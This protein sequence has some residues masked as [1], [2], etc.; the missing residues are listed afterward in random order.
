MLATRIILLLLSF[1]LPSFAG[2]SVLRFHTA[3]ESN[4]QQVNYYTDL[5]RMVIAETR[6]DYPEIRLQQV[7]LSMPQSRLVMNLQSGESFDLAWL[8][9]S[10]IREKNLLPIRIPLLKGLMG[11]RLLLINK[12]H[13]YKFSDIS[14]LA[15][16][17]TLVG[18]Q[19]FEWP[20]T[21]ILIHNE[22][23]LTAGPA[24]TM[25][26]MLQANRF[27]YFPRSI[28]EIWHE[29]EV[30]DALVVEQN[31]VLHYPTAVYFFVNLDNKKLA[32]RIEIGLQRAIKS[33]KFEEIFK[34]YERFSRNINKTNIE[35]RTIIELKNTDMSAQTRE[36]IANSPFLLQSKKQ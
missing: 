34:R 5:L 33:G 6:V 35:Q 32:Q 36:I 26:K 31:L 23:I 12:G 14:T 24:A 30:F 15:Q 7:N 20:D 29:A 8:M 11:Y 18:G 27:D 28:I 1:T 4:P 25:H 10:K 3:P 13:Q 22:L 17:K 9:T 21:E 16:L 19:S 2:G